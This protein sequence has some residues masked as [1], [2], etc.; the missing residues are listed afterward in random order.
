MSEAPHHD[1]EG[2]DISSLRTSYRTTHSILGTEQ[3]QTLLELV[4]RTLRTKTV[5]LSLLIVCWTVLQHSVQTLLGWDTWAAIFTFQYSHPEYIWTLVTASLSHLHMEHMLF[6]VIALICIGVLAESLVLPQGRLIRA[7]LG[8]SIVSISAQFVH[9]LLLNDAVGYF[10]GASGGIAGLC[11]MTAVCLPTNYYGFPIEELDSKIFQRGLSGLFRLYHVATIIVF[12]LFF[13]PIVLYWLG[14][15]FQTVAPALN[16]SSAHIAH[17]AGLVA[18][19]MYG[20]YLRQSG[21]V[22][23]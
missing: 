20:I 1:A 14:G 17:I 16:P 15:P 7:F 12:G 23:L 13:D 5:A 8:F 2:H 18:G 11:M 21:N 19:L 22:K 6:N 10:V 4:V 9:G 3:P